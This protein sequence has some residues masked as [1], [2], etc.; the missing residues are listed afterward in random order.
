MIKFEAARTRTGRDVRRAAV[1][2]GWSHVLHCVSIAA[3]LTDG[4]LVHGIIL[5]SIIHANTAP[6]RLSNGD[7]DYDAAAN[8]PDDSLREPVSAYVIAKQLGLP[9]ETVRR[10]VAKLITEGRCVRVGPRAGIVVPIS[11]IRDLRPEAFLTQSLESLR[12]LVCELDRI[13]AVHSQ[14]FPDSD[15]PLMIG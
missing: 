9:Y 8:L 1:R 4:D 12:A 5:M 2:H 13:G 11:A 3:S 6:L 14:S 7:H 10:H 15:R